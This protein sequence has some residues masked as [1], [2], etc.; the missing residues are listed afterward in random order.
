[1]VLLE[2]G[3][4]VAALLAGGA[5]STP[6]EMA[7]LVRAW[8]TSYRAAWENLDAS[9]IERLFASDGQHRYNP[10]AP[11]VA[12][13][14]LR[15]EWDRLAQRQRDNFLDFDVVSIAPQRTYVLW[16]CLTTRPQSG[17]REI[18]WGVFAMV[19]KDSECL[20]QSAW[21]RTEVAMS[22][23]PSV[24]IGKLRSAIRHLDDNLGERITVPELARSCRLS[25]RHAS[26]LFRVFTDLSVHQYLVRQRLIQA[27]ER[28]A[29]GEESIVDVAYDLGFASQAHFI[30]AFKQSTTFTPAQY[31]VR[32]DSTER[33]P[34]HAWLDAFRGTLTPG[35]F[36]ALARCFEVPKAHAIHRDPSLADHAI[37][38]VE[39][40]IVAD[41][42]AIALVHWA[43]RLPADNR[44]QSSGDGML[45]LRFAPDGTCR[46][47]DNYCHWN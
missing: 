10:F 35:S 27:R 26:R 39:L 37:R 6:R 11:P 46:A 1:M 41:T 9:L 29:W 34:V 13:D 3:S 17:K 33:G 40:E 14:Q 44:A 15:W 25:T 30:S 45:V 8:M 23:A 42:P 5:R 2:A 38:D 36:P 7:A 43:L 12:H 31:R 19:F 18:V 47:K 4:V 20:E 24:P 16:R 28:L 32:F 21:S 22:V